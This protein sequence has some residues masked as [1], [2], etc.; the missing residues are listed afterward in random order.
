M[1]ERKILRMGNPIL[2][3]IAKPIKEFNTP[4]LSQLIEDMKDTM[5]AN[6]GVGL[7]AIQIGI[8]KRVII[9]GFEE[10]SRYPQSPAIPLTVLINPTFKILEAESESS[11]EGCLSIPGMR[12]LVPRFK[13]IRYSG[14][15]L[16][17]TKITRDVS[18]F[19]A[20]VFQHELDHLDGL[21]YV[22]KI[23]NHANFGFTQELELANTY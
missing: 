5:I 13:K 9:F 6:D 4:Q 2:R 7:A 20:R 22:D 1:A 11:W 21:L 15:D 8:L 14:Y 3:E 16:L 17:G 10:S 23:E 12:G 18:D 19:H